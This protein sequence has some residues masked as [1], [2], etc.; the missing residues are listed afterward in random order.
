MKSKPR[1]RTLLALAPLPLALIWSSSAHAQAMA[2]SAAGPAATSPQASD[3]NAAASAVSAQGQG[4]AAVSEVVV[5]GIRASLQSAENIKRDSAEIVDSIVASDIG[6]LPDRNV[7]EALQRVAGIQIQRNYGEGSSVAIRGLTQVRTELNG[8]DI[9]TAGNPNGVGAGLS[10]EDVPAELLA[11]VDVY[12]NPSADQIEDQLAGIIDFRTRKPFDFNGLKFAANASANYYDLTQRGGP[13]ASALISDRWNTG[14]GQIGALVDVAY[15]KDYFQDD[16]V[17]TEPFYTLDQSVGVNGTPNNPQDA[18]IAAALGRTGKVTNLPQG[19]G[20][21][22]NYGGRQRFGLDVALQWKPSDTLSFTGEVFRNNYKFNIEG[23]A[24]FAETGVPGTPLPGAPFQFAADGDYESGTF[25]NVALSSYASLN[26]RDSTTTDYSLSALWT[27]APHLEVTAD[28]Q[29]VDSSTNTA[30]FIVISNGPN[31]TYQQN[32]S[33]TVASFSTIPATATTN[34]ALY[35]NNGFL[36]D[37][38]QSRGSEKSGRIDVKYSFDNSMIRSLR[39]GLRYADE[40]TTVQDTGY[41]YTGITGLGTISNYSLAGFFRGDANVFGSV[42]TYPVGAIGNYQQDLTNFG[43][44]GPPPYLP[45]GFSAQSQK[46]YSGYATAFFDA[47]PLQI[48]LDGNVGVRVVKTDVAV[49]GFY[50]QIPLN[51]GSDGSISTGDPQYQQIAFSNSYTKALPSLNLRY[52]LTPKLQLRSALSGNLARPLLSNLNPSL[53][54]TEPGPAQVNEI[55]TASGGNPYL[56]PMTSHNADLSLEYYFSHNGFVSV[57]GFYKEISGYIQTAVAPRNITFPD[58]KTYT[59]QV[60]SYT[61][62]ANATVKGAEVSYQQ[63]YDFLPAPLDGLGL[64]ANFT[65]VDSQAPS[66]AISGPPITVPLEFLSKY[67]YNLI[68]IYEKGPFSARLAYNWRS[69]F[70]ET[71]AG[72]GTGNL[73]LFDKPY[74]QLD[75]SINYEVTPHFSI[76]ADARNINNAL[77]QSYFGITTE[78]RTATIADRRIS[79]LG[80]VTY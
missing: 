26:Q 42:E 64:Q 73:P 80:R 19:G 14:I 70:V 23:N 27:P 58:G 37:F 43:I 44:S 7:A 6:K 53:S 56:K 68:G 5:T 4:S 61:N 21:N 52:H 29:Y 46:I 40:Q 13:S 77:K 33:G 18:A 12:K 45:S 54:L 78:P 34:P 67:S 48:P 32:V 10:L 30:N 63:F 1:R 31:T 51:V 11:G 39:A 41:R 60:T 72:V 25:T 22:R 17:S 79:I 28:G 15:Q 66:P 8:R 24:F 3:P 35:S 74:G 57:A 71:T 59:Y 75:G 50:Q 16:Q 47:S 38:S 9:F 69:T 20:L 65:Y 2:T 62:A 36:D 76:G 55:H 49:S